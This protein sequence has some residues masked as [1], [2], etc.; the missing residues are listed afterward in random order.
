MTTRR[1]RTGF[2]VVAAVALAACAGAAP[3][4]ETVGVTSPPPPTA[5]PTTAAAPSSTAAAPSTT[6]TTAAPT[7]TTVPTTTTTLEPLQGLALE[8]VAAGLAQPTAVVAAGDRM[9]IVERTG[10][11][12]VVDAGGLAEEPFLDISA[13]VTSNGIEQGMLGLAL[14]PDFA[15]NGRF[16]VYYVDPDGH[17][18]LSEFHASGDTADPGSERVL[19]ALP[20]PPGSVDI[21]HYGG[22]LMFGPDGYLYAGLG[23]GADARGQGQNRDTVFGTILRLDVDGPEPYG[24][25]ADNP[26]AEGGAP[27]VWAYGLRNPWRFTIDAADGLMYIADVGQETWEE[28]NVVSLGDGGAN[29]GW[30]DSEGNH[31]FLDSDCDLATFVTPA[32]EYSHDEGCSVTGGHV[33]RGQRIPELA[34]HYFY[35]DWC[36]GW[37]R[38]FRYEG[39]QATD[40]AEWPD[41][42][43]GQVNTFGVD[44][45]GEMYVAAYSGEVYRIVPLR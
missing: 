34:G 38:T 21:R 23:E 32:V 43:P 14:H 1:G 37:V 4:P 13:D 17:R 5:P 7:T 30:P 15:S 45:D 16:F 12:R 22:M 41:L 8:P 44:S 24:I 2:A 20:Q 19:F 35:S 9:L 31:C 10:R 26:F 11:I 29:L 6:R 42:E 18:R 3:S 25:P 39:G 36:R 40:L 27:E 33:Y 28:I